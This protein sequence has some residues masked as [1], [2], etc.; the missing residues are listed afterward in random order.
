M[1]L[2]LSSVHRST[3]RAR[4]HA[5]GRR[6]RR[7]WVLE[8]LEGRVLLSGNPTYY[9]VNSR[10]CVAH[11]RARSRQ[12]PGRRRDPSNTA[13]RL[14]LIAIRSKRPHGPLRLVR[15]AADG[16]LGPS[17]IA[18]FSFRCVL[19]FVSSRTAPGLFSHGA[20]S[21]ALSHPT[22]RSRPHAD[23]LFLLRSRQLAIHK[24]RHRRPPS[25]VRSR[26]SSRSNRERCCRRGSSTRTSRGPRT[27][28]WGCLGRRSAKRLARRVRPTRSWWKRAMVTAGPSRSTYPI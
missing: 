8:G 5:R 19:M 14:L 13:R 26:D 1:S 16:S 10:R 25:R 12:R 27:E 3:S 24:L 6:R 15:A 20:G 22:A 21:I 23:S 9:T 4:Q 17:S 11:R 28:H 7:L 2:R 18:S